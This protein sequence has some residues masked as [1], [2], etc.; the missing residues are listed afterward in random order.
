MSIPQPT[1]VAVSRWLSGQLTDIVTPQDNA[2]G[3]DGNFVVVSFLN[4]VIKFDGDSN[5]M[6]RFP[7]GVGTARSTAFQGCQSNPVATG[8]CIPFGTSVSEISTDA[9]VTVEIDATS[10]VIAEIVNSDVTENTGNT[11]PSGGGGAL[12]YFF[13]WFAALQLL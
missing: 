5:F 13:L 4:E 3:S 6:M 11:T 1:A 2:F 12:D 8:A 7:T 9:D 10:N